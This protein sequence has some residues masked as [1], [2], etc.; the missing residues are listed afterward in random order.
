MGQLS[1]KDDKRAQ[2]SFTASL[3]PAW[4]QTER[5]GVN[6][7]RYSGDIGV[8]KCV[9]SLVLVFRID[10]AE[11]TVGLTLNDNQIIVACSLPIWSSAKIGDG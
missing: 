5:V 2:S 1:S 10:D 7:F 8:E 4:R 9:G 3:E 6:P 11:Y